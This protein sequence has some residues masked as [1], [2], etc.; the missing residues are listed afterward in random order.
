MHVLT[1]WHKHKSSRIHF[2]HKVIEMGEIP[3][4]IMNPLLPKYAKSSKFSLSVETE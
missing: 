3:G 2:T 4:G 1:H